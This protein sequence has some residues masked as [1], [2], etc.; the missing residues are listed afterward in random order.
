MFVNKKRWNIAPL[1]PQS[2][3]G[4]MEQNGIQTILGRV[5]SGRGYQTPDSAL[6][7]LGV[8]S[9]SQDP[10]MMKGMEQAV[11]R[12]LNATVSSFFNDTDASLGQL[13]PRADMYEDK[14]NFFVRAEVPGLK[15]EDLHVE[16]GEGVVG[17]YRLSGTAVPLV[18][19][20]EAHER[21][22]QNSYA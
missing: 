9:H 17:I 11:D 6:E 10:F 22:R 16:L 4:A 3:I 21:A 1:A 7:F 14:D 2:Y 12:L 15:K 20:G 5:F 18:Q 19:E 13:Y 8:Y